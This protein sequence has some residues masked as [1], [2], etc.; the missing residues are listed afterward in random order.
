MRIHRAFSGMGTLRFAGD[1]LRGLM[2]LTPYPVPA[3]RVPDPVV[4]AT[5]AGEH[6]GP[7][8]TG[9]GVAQIAEG[10]AEHQTDWA[11]RAE[12]GGQ[13]P[14]PAFCRLL[15]QIALPGAGA[16]P[17]P[18]EADGAVPWGALALLARMEPEPLALE[19]LRDWGLILRA[20]LMPWDPPSS[21][22]SRAALAHRYE[23]ATLRWLVQRMA[24]ERLLLP[25]PAAPEQEEDATP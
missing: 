24:F 18:F 9:F 6:P 1:V 2:K 11:E 13:A 20:A 17:S 23:R 21:R 22:A 5:A 8:W 19:I 12:F 25:L 14:S 4:T 7:E 3:E 10:L 15:D 16:F